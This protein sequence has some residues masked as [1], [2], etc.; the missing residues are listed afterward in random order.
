METTIRRIC[1]HVMRSTVAAIDQRGM[2][3]ADLDQA[4]SVLRCEIKKVI[5]DKGG[6]YGAEVESIIGRG[7]DFERDWESLILK[8][9]DKITTK[10]KGEIK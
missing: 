2:E 4:V 3:I 10:T 6:E 1:D 8:I 5:T 7:G 9:A